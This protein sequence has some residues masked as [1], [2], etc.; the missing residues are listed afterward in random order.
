[1]ESS[2]STCIITNPNSGSSEQGR[3][4]LELIE[5]RPEFILRES[6][7]EGHARELAREAA[8]EGFGTVAAA[9][10]D[11]TVHEVANGL[12]T[13]GRRATLGLIPL[14]TGN[15]LARTL[16]VPLDP[17]DALALLAVGR[18]EPLDAIR[19]T[20]P[21]TALFGINVAA[22][23]FSGEV[24]D[25]LTPELKA[26]WGP[27]AYL[28]GAVGHLPDLTRYETYISWDD[29]PP[30]RTDAFNIIVANGRTA[31]GGRNVA[32]WANPQDGLLDVVIVHCGTVVEMAEVVARLM[33]GNYLDSKLVEYRQVKTL[34]VD[35]NPGMWF[36]ADGELLTREPVRFEAMPGA[37]PVVVGSD[38]TADVRPR[39]ADQTASP[40]P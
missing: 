35:S 21:N 10:G 6:A 25:A 9:G 33:A 38:F 31:A 11:G 23:G 1:M 16:A 14:G 40:A 36:N 24:G 39:E 18:R 22:G 3:L 20:A 29:A 13:A 7:R 17:R 26:G 27:L 37:L 12:L 34:T 8:E 30:E 2:E 15:D 28:I 32:P 19:I 4:L 5:G